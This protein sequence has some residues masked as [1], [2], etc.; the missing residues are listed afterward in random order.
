M[1]CSSPAGGATHTR[2]FAKRPTICGTCEG[3]QVAEDMSY[4]WP[5]LADAELASRQDER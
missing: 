1:K 4:K 3:I 5:I 2:S